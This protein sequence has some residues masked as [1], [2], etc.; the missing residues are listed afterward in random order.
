MD[1]LHSD[2]RKNTDPEEND[3][4]SQAKGA[5]ANDWKSK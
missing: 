4:A 3:F 5:I 1:Y 2:S